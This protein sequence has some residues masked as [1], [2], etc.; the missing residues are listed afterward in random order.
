MRLK[1]LKI[2]PPEKSWKP[3][4][5]GGGGGGR[6]RREGTGGAVSVGRITRMQV[7]NVEGG[8]DTGYVHM[9]VCGVRC[10]GRGIARGREDAG[11]REGVVEGEGGRWASSPLRVQMGLRTRS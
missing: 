5:R 2:P 8:E 9:I 7:G 10:I 6:G 3:P 1:G 4:W 11:G